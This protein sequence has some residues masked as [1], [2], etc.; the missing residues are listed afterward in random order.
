[1]ETVRIFYTTENGR[2]IMKVKPRS[3]LLVNLY[4]LYKRQIEAHAHNANNNIVGRVWC[5]SSQY[6]AWHWYCEDDQEA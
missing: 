1:M 6:P 2:H 5:D 3:L 4:N